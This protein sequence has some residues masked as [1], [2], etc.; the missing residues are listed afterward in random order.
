VDV[1]DVEVVV[2]DFAGLP[3]WG[4]CALDLSAEA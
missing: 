2:V 4:C 3:R 1:F